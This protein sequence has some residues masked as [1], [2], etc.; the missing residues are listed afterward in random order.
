M[1][2]LKIKN[3]Y[4]K[5][6]EPFEPLDERKK[7]VTIYS[8]GPTVYSYA[9]IGN[10]RSFL[11]ADVLRRVLEQHGYAVRQVMNVTDVGHLTQDHLAD[12]EG[13]DRLS[14]AARELGKDPY[15]VAAH[16]EAAFVRDAKLLRLKNHQPPD[17]DDPSLHPRATAYVAEMLVMIDTLIERGFAYVVPS[18]EVYFEVSKFPEYGRLSGKVLD[19]LEAGARVAVRDEKKDPRDFALWKVDH[20]HLMNWDPHGP[21]GW[22][23]GDYAR[24][25]KLAPNGVD[26][27][28]GKGFPGWH[29]ECSAMSRALL[30]DAIDVHTGGE[31]NVFPHHE[32]EI[33]QSFGATGAGTHAPPGSPDD[34][35][36]RKSFA[37][38]WVH[39]RHLLVD[40]RKM[41]KRDGTFFTV[42]DFLD[43]R[44][45]GRPELVE[46][47]VEAGFSSG[48]VPP[49]VLRYAL[50][51]NAYTQ[52][53]NFTF[54]LLGQAKA[55][56]ERLQSRYDRLREQAGEGAPRA[57]VTA[58]LQAKGGAFDRALDDDLNM[59]NALAAVFELVTALNHLELSPGEAREA[60]ALFERI[61]GVL[62]V[63]DRTVDGGVVTH[64]DI[65]ARIAAIDDQP[66]PETL[67]L[68]AI[69][70]AIVQRAA[71]KKA[72]AFAEADAIREQ[73][74]ARGVLIEDTSA[75]VRW[76]IV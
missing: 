20:K 44:S 73:L 46:R 23:E 37:R 30:G 3:S 38:Y 35:A 31:D 16:F 12:A 66:I 74:K 62:D 53:M 7:S 48:S 59:P 55:S 72:R 4:T 51:S 34:G 49:R 50:I 21:T 52:P 15:A 19:E 2:V 24:F 9:H 65:A 5:S 67:D 14:K 70:R 33:A 32:C 22:P 29:I 25:Q 27:R 17:A 6:I 8:C 13:E 69:E 43:P 64:A 40:G 71:K 10:F 61:D 75:G 42:H 11:F 57:E 36:I 47:L 76:K 26:R 63:F 68:Q 45:S 41:A 56:V 18:G 58:L 1:R 39:G 28:I 60:L 54:D